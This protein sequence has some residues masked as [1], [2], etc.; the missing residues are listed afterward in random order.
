MVSLEGT[1]ARRLDTALVKEPVEAIVA[2]VSFISLTLA[3]SAALKL[4]APGAWLVALI[5]PQFE[6]GREAVGK[7]GVVRDEAAREAAVARVRDFVAGVPGWS[8]LGVM[9]SPIEG[10]G[11]NKE[12]L[13]AALYESR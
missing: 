10:G 12:F 4:V 7:G 13:L 2:D 11:G 3:L 1:D 9:P 8:V 6:A 5:K